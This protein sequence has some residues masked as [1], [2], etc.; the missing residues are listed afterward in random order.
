MLATP[1]LFKV[2]NRP[3]CTRVVFDSIRKI[4]P[5]RLYVAQDGPRHGRADDV[6]N[7]AAVRAIVEQVDWP[8][9]V[10]TLYEKENKG[11]RLSVACAID[12][13]FDKVEQGII[14]EDDCL[15]DP[16]FYTFCEYLLDKYKDVEQVKMISGSNFRDGT[17]SNSASY[18]FSK[19]PHIWGWASWRRAWKGYDVDM[20]DWP[21]FFKAG[22]LR[23]MNPILRIGARISF[24]AAY[25]KKVNTW[26][27]QWA[28]KMLKDNGISICPGVNMISNIGFGSSGT[29]TKGAS[30]FA[31][32]K[33][34]PIH[35]I[36]DPKE[37]VV[38]DSA[39]RN[40]IFSI[41]REYAKQWLLRK[42]RF[43]VRHL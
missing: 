41:Y 4:R 23:K 32:I 24:D 34:F 27:T 3:D 38:D 16:T 42:L 9:E 6:A 14:L 15:P 19:L 1:I 8:C 5:V 18:F 7:C 13:F 35:K 33:S 10:E 31:N 25:Q 2:F 37:I 26:D 22:G 40:E 17:G 30:R 12:W 39:D 11:C 28:Y 36:V 21:E 29:H 20:T 43:R